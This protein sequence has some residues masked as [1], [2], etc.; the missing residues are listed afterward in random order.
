MNLSPG[1]S[2]TALFVFFWRNTAEVVTRWYQ[3]ETWPKLVL[4]ESKW[5]LCMA[6]EKKGTRQHRV[7]PQRHPGA[8]MSFFLNYRRCLFVLYWPFFILISFSF[9]M[10]L[11][12]WSAPNKGELTTLETQ[13]TYLRASVNLKVILSQSFPAII[14]KLNNN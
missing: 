1:P 2:W 4:R 8:Q 3:G 6:Q 5:A 10:Y 12:E 14:Y 13:L 7:E 9:V 11:G